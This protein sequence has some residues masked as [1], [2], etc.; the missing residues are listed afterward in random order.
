MKALTMNA[1]P[2]AT[3]VAP[4]TYRV[5]EAATQPATAAATA[6]AGFSLPAR[7]AAF[8]TTSATISTVTPFTMNTGIR[9][10]QAST[11]SRPPLPTIPIW[12]ASI[13]SSED[14][15][16]NAR[17]SANA[18]HESPSISAGVRLHLA[19]AMG[20]GVADDQQ[21]V[22]A[23]QAHLGAAS[24]VAHHAGDGVNV[25][26]GRTMNLPEGGR[27]QLVAKLL[28]GLA[29][30]RFLRGGDHP[31]VLAVGL[32]ITHVIHGDDAHRRAVRRVDPAQEAALR[33]AELAQQS[34]DRRRRPAD[35]LLEARHG[36]SEPGRIGGLEHVVR[37]SLLERGEGVLV[38][39]RHEHDMA[40]AAHLA[41]HLEAGE[42]RHLDVE[43]Q[44]VGRMRFDLPQGRDAVARLRD[45]VKIRPERAEQ[46]REL[47]AQQRLVLGNDGAWSGQHV[48]P[49]A[50][51]ACS[52]RRC[53]LACCVHRN[54]KSV[55][56]EPGNSG[57]PRS[58]LPA[59]SAF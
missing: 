32:E 59:D 23:L 15:A 34:F 51:F 18:L 5:T 20:I 49:A 27:I 14:R 39:G 9:T 54:P 57:S 17:T 10:S 58:G 7:P 55:S 31:R 35:A 22:S 53:Q 45:D 16:Q 37:G 6:R 2:A 8:R 24:Q 1:G 38:V 52:G 12:G 26:D 30:Q 43:E 50:M 25:D 40:A 33:G 44:H 48:G 41:R 42:P 28:D 46:L 36:R 4:M 3:G 29:D 13:D 21:L 47:L 11:M 19:E 56:W